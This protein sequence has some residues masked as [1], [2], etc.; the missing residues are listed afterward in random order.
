MNH[1][2][3]NLLLH[4]LTT[5]AAVFLI[6][7]FS[8]NRP[9][10]P[11]DERLLFD[12]TLFPIPRTLGEI[13]EIIKTFGLNYHLESMNTFFSNNLTIRSNPLDA[14]F[15]IIT[16]YLF[17]TNAFLY[18]FFQIILHL[19][20][21]FLVWLI[22][23]NIL[24]IITVD[25][26]NT[27]SIFNYFLVSILTLFWGVHGASSEAIL[28]ITNN[29]AILTYTFCFLFILFEVRRFVK[30]DF[31]VSFSHITLF[32]SLFCITM[33]LTEYGYTLPL[34][35]FFLVLSLSYKESSSVVQSF[36][37]AFRLSLPYFWGLV[38]F[39]AILLTRSHSP[40]E[41]F[42]NSFT[43]VENYS[44]LYAFIERNLWL[45]PQ[46]FIHLLKL[47]LFPV[48]LSTYQSS[49]TKITE[50]LIN[51]YS[52]FST[53]TYLTC[54]I[55]PL[56]FF[57]IFKTRRFSFIFLLAY[58]F[59]FSLLPF[60]HIVLPTYCLSADRYCYFPIFF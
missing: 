43:G 8:L 31:E 48:T 5:L 4:I 59:Y 17:K 24:K 27:L 28:L 22:L 11:F 1:E 41:N 38:A 49:L 33:L 7:A 21:T 39:I 58:T 13:L 52:I 16:L 50:T 54:L 14:V 6:Y 57:C 46:I 47:I 53:L 9:W 18:H 26:K 60:L 51:P 10:Q 55:A 3:K 45:T 25:K 37:Q 29:D 42:T 35:I 23:Y 20:N 34:I 12:E 32:A 30:N 19:I 15:N 56:I 36:K 2:Q 44:P 40:L